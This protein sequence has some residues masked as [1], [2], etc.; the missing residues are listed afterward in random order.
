M[1]HLSKPP[2]RVAWLGYGGLLPFIALA[3]LAWL[4]PEHAPFCL[5]ALLSYGAVILSF[6]GAL[7][8]GFAVAL[9]E[10]EDDLRSA[11]YLWSVIPAL[12]AW[13]ALLFPQKLA[14]ALLASGF[15]LQYWRDWA[16][17]KRSRLPGW[18]LGLRLELTVVA[19]LCLAAGELVLFGK[20]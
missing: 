5:H 1:I 15:L 11:S 10:L 20:L 19:S 7:H 17:A 13:V 2:R 8:W 6:V 16:L 4:R 14:F 3:G 18:Y 9:P 12:M